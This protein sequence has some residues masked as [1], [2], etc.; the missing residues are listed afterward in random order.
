MRPRGLFIGEDAGIPLIIGRADRLREQKPL[1]LLGSDA[2]FPFR[3]RPSQ[4]VVA[5]IPDG[6]I[7]CM[8]LLDEW[9]VASRLASRSGFPGCFEGS[10]TQL[11]ER[12]LQ[13]LS[14]EGLAEVGIFARGPTALL[15]GLAE[16]AQRYG[17]PVEGENCE[18]HHP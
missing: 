15:E 14:Q 3:T 5:G 9:G 7:A 13:A 2:P 18:M 4:I 8:P 16:L 12:W 11:A 6:C 10:V 1:V 17:V